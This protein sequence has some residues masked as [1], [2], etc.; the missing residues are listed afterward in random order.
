MRLV[1]DTN[2]LISGLLSQ[3]APP[4][5]LLQ[6]WLEGRYELATSSAQIEELTRVLAYDKLQT[7]I[8]PEHAV[9][10]IS[11]LSALAIVVSDLPTIRL[12][13]DP[14]DN[15][16]LATTVA[17]QADGLV[18]GDKADLLAHRSIHGIPIITA[19]QALTR[20][21]EQEMS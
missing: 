6:Q 13:K 20:L 11:N 7:R 18:S 10:L 5:Q 1:L 12:S 9:D 3:T 16:I 17:S 8:P 14:F 21:N 15:V 4:A 2:I 19:R